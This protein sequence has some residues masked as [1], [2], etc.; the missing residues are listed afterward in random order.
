MKKLSLGV[1]EK[2]QRQRTSH[3]KVVDDWINADEEK[4]AEKRK[5]KR[6]SRHSFYISLIKEGVLY[7]GSVNEDDMKVYEF[8]QVNHWGAVKRN[9][10]VIYPNKDTNRTYATLMRNLLGYMRRFVY[11]KVSRPSRKL[12]PLSK[13]IH[14]LTLDEA[15][16][17]FERLEMQYLRDKKPNQLQEL[18]ILRLIFLAKENVEIKD[19]LNARLSDV[20]FS[21]NSVQV[22]LKLIDCSEGFLKLLRSHSDSR[23][24]LLFVKQNGDPILHGFVSKAIDKAG[25]AIKIGRKVTPQSLQKSFMH[26]MKAEGIMYN[27]IFTIKYR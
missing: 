25:S 18:L 15:A 7:T 17:L 19:V 26:I 16:K 3:R 1:L 14:P 2:E 9:L 8:L 12:K 4:D 10:D 11:G 20:D 23:S 22:G 13:A 27:E 24:D 6:K 5:E 21:K